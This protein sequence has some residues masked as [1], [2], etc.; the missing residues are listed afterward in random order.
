L[1]ETLALLLAAPLPVI[2]L[3]RFGVRCMRHWRRS[4][5][6]KNRDTKCP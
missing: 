1:D 3:L 6:S 4:I 5:K 2:L